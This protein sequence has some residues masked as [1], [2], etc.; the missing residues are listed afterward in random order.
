MIKVAQAEPLPDG[1][2]NGE[3]WNREV[4]LDGVKQN[5]A[6]AL[7]E[8]AYCC[9]RGIL[10]LPYDRKLIYQ[11]AKTASQKGSILGRRMLAKCIGHGEGVEINSRK[12]FELFT[13]LCKVTCPDAKVDFAWY[14]LNGRFVEKNLPKAEELIT[15]AYEAGSVR[16]IV[17][18]ADLENQKELAKIPS[19]KI[20][21]LYVEAFRKVPDIFNAYEIYHLE[22]DRKLD[23]IDQSKKS[24]L[25]EKARRTVS[26]GMDLR[27]PHAFITQ[28]FYE[29]N[30]P[31]GDKHLGV[32]L[33]VKSANLGGSS[34]MANLTKWMGGGLTENY[35][36]KYQLLAIGNSRDYQEAGELAVSKGA[37][38]WA[39]RLSYA[40]KLSRSEGKDRKANHKKAANLLK[41]LIAEGECNAH[42][43]L[44]IQRIQEH[45][46][47]K[48]LEREMNQ[49]FA[50]LIYHSNHSSYSLYLLGLF[51][52]DKAEVTYAPVKQAAV[53]RFSLS[54]FGGVANDSN[55]EASRRLPALEKGLSESQLKALK[56]L[57]DQG[58][59]SAKRFREPAY[60]LLVKSG[61]LPKGWKFDQ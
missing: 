34:A 31:G 29:F 44:G 58:F 52:G 46:K 24:A 51:Y 56:V 1:A 21:N 9:R 5:Q 3:I 33:Q 23:G 2:W 25:L 49:G 61:D 19:I 38:S 20:T 4:L 50:H 36:G 60:Q 26:R 41:D 32:E 43:V 45:I 12:A 59:P 47:F 18:K 8:W 11:R 7:A 16:A 48:G 55:K 13:S 35:G 30:I 27:H 22:S 40:T 28:S 57:E 15:Q 54:K 10:N 14:Y 42:D 53:Y 17:A 37:R 39:A 6:D